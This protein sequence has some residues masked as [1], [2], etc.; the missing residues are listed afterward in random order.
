[1]SGVRSNNWNI[2][3]HVAIENLKRVCIWLE[4]LRYRYNQRYVW[5]RDSPPIGG[6]SEADQTTPDPSYSGVESCASLPSPAPIIGQ[7]SEGAPSV[8]P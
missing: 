3:N 7:E 8:C 1:M 2:P 5:G 4:A 6:E